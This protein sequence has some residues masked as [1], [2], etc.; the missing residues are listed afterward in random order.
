M[1]KVNHPQIRKQRRANG[2]HDAY[3]VLSG[4]RI[5]LGKW[6]SPEAQE[7]YQS[8]VAEWLARGCRP[9]VPVGD[10][11][12][13]ECVAAYKSYLNDYYRN[14]PAS[15]NRVKYV[16]TH[17]VHLYGRM[18]AE[19]FT[20]V[21]LRAVRE[22][23]IKEKLART[24]INERIRIIIN[25]LKYCASVEMIPPEPYQKAATLEPLKPGRSAARETE[26]VKPVPQEHIDAVLERVNISIAAMI[27]L[28]LLTGCRPGEIVGLKRED[29]DTA[30]DVWIL[31]LQDHKNAWRG[32]ERILYFGKKAQAIL[33]A[34]FILRKP[35]EYLFQP[36]DC[37]RERTA[38][39]ITHRRPNQTDNPRK[40]ERTIS[41]HY[42]VRAYARAILNACA[43]HPLK[44]WK[45]VPAW[46]PNQLR[47]NAASELRRQYGIEVTRA[48]LGHSCL[49]T[50]EIYA[51][52]DQSVVIKIMREIG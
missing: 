30:G 8:A 18:L 2:G 22:C 10:A 16:F 50:S 14:S 26:P 29:L 28:Q 36:M 49:S 5:P 11:T 34:F 35:G 40:S 31:E 13:I 47:H 19:E 39:G 1:P 27:R 23:L 12:I 21:H 46:S 25:M 9:V 20:A 7:K 43:E 52:A 17:L 48:V 6:K 15:L 32:R 38:A 24:T 37:Y 51:E 45:K 44:K 4:Q 3:V 33:K 42:D 41:D